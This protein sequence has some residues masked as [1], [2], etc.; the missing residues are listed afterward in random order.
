ME[1][2]VELLNASNGL[3]PRARVNFRLRQHAGLCPETF[4]NAA[5]ECPDSRR[6]DQHWC[7][8]LACGFLEPIAYQGDELSEPR[9]LHGEVFVVA[10]ADNRLGEILL[11]FGGQRD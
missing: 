7:F 11:P 8:A 10:L 6:C 4:D 2:S 3:Q 1:L 9:W 5:Y